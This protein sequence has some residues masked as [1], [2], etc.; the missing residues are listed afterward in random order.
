MHPSVF[1]HW[2]EFSEP[3]EGR[4]HSMYLD[5]KGL[6]TTGVGNLIDS[7]GT[8]QALPWKH[9]DARL[10]T[11]AEVAAAWRELKSRQ[12]FAKLHWKYAAKLNDLRLTDADIDALVADKLRG[13]VAF[14]ERNYFTAW[15][16]FPADAQLAILSMAWAL[17]PGFPKTFK[18]CAR[19]IVLQDWLAAAASC[20]IKE[21]GNPGVVPRNKRNRHCFANAAAVVAHDMPREILHWPLVAAS[22]AVLT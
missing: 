6:V 17:G 5:V 4:V 13:N 9:A 1:N 22:P 20:T 8:A 19:A 12:E 10:A 3:L 7:V 21:A 16:T 14:L 15:D 11:K 2:H 18:N